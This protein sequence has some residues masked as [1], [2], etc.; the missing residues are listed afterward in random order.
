M[1]H[2]WLCLLC[3]L[4]G[5]NQEVGSVE[6]DEFARLRRRMVEEQLR[7]RDIAEPEVLRAMGEVPRHLFVPERLREYAYEDHALAIEAGQTISQPYIVA[8]MTQA[9]QVGKGDRVLEIGTGSGYQA[10]VLA[11]L[12]VRLYSIEIVPG[13]AASARK[14]LAALGYDRVEVRLGDGNLGWP[15]QAPFAAIIVT[16]APEHIPPALVSQL[17]EGGRLVLPV[18]KGEQEL[19]RLTRTGGETR[20][21]TLLPVRFVPMTGKVQKN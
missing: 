2:C 15:E 11:E 4:A 14:R 1:W 6:E 5:C 18:G 7:R 13:L 8:F 17:A 3:W 16:A 12:G 20:V 9:L 10:A 21:D 19:L